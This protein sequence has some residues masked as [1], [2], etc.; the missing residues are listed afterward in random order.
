MKMSEESIE[1]LHDDC[2]GA[3]YKIENELPPDHTLFECWNCGE[4]W[5]R[6]DQLNEIEVF[7]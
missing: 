4:L 5:E 2:D 7:F 6:D 1:C 3:C